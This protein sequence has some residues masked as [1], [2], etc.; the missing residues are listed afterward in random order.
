MGNVKT[1]S[2]GRRYMQEPVTIRSLHR[3]VKSYRDNNERI[4]KAQEEIIQS[5]N[6]LH[7]QVNKYFVTN[8]EASSIQVTTSRLQ[9]KRDDHGND[10][11]SR[12]MSRHHHSTRKFTRITHAS[13]GL[14]SIQRV[15]LI[16]R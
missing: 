8:Q 13:S 15:Y 7:K 14:G 1:D 12:S 6:M 3:E 10:R 2:N 4:M 11:K 5:L 9:S 16:W